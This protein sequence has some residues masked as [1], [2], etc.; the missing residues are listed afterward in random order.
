MT[1]CKFCD[2][3]VEVI[4]DGLCN[5]C[6]P[7]VMKGIK[8]HVDIIQD[9]FKL[10]ET[11]ENGKTYE[12]LLNLI[13]KSLKTL[14]K[15]YVSKGINATNFDIKKAIKEIEDEKKKLKMA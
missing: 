1:T 14:D 3:E 5:E 2:N 15:E 4:V 12:G 9:S 7:E 10:A 6:H 13:I 8:K 11:T